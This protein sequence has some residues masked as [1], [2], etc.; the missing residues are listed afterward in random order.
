MGPPEAALSSGLRPRGASED[1][2]PGLSGRAARTAGAKCS[3]RARIRANPIP[4]L[5]VCS[6]VVQG[7]WGGIAFAVPT[8]I[9]VLSEVA[10]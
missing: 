2:V 10:K 8:P 6:S 9:D 1:F 4:L 7:V 5:L 3:A